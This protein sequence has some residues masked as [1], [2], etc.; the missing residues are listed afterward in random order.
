[1]G[2]TRHGLK[3]AAQRPEQ[4]AKTEHAFLDTEQTEHDA[5]FVAA[6]EPRPPLS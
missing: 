3:F 4:H 6:E 2:R 5:E 1:M